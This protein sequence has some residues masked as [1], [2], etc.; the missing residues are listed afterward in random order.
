MGTSEKI[1]NATGISKDIIDRCKDSFEYWYRYTS[2]HSGPDLIPSHLIMYVFNHIAL[3]PEKLWPK[4]I[5]V[6]GMVNYDGTKMS[7]SLGNVIPLGDAVEKYGADII[8]FIE[9]A[10]GDLGT[11]VDFNLSSVNG[12]K[13]KNQQL[14]DIIGDLGNMHSNPLSGIDYWLYSK[15]NSKI[16]KAN[17]SMAEISIRE[18]Y[19]EIYYNSVNEL[20]WYFDMGGYNSLVVKEFMEKLTLMLSPIMP[21][22]SEEF[23]HML[24]NKTLVSTER[25]PSFDPNMINADIETAHAQISGIIDDVN[26]ILGIASAAKS[27]NERMPKALHI[28]LAEKWKYDAYGVLLGNRNIG[29]TINDA[30]RSARDILRHP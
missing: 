21:H 29:E 7:K 24:G 13:Q 8:R 14:Y 28:I 1:S 17:R 5:V 3:F 22:I 15:L 16:D 6:N 30:T 20:K 11:D 25:W 10:N 12:I 9:I 19:I 4:Q 23:W 27:N 26:S 2:R 18:A